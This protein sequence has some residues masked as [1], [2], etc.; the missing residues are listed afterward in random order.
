MLW[1]CCGL[2]YAVLWL[3]AVL[4]GD[5]VRSLLSSELGFSVEHRNLNVKRI[6]F[7][8]GEVVKAGGIVISALI[9]PYKASRYG[10]ACAVAVLCCVVLCCAVL[11]CDVLLLCWFMN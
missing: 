6:G 4:D 2:C 8:A 1:L 3:H 5:F 10:V 7:V 9:A 11:C